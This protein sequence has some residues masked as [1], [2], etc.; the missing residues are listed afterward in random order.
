M[1]EVAKIA[2]IAVV[3]VLFI[4]ILTT[5][6][7]AEPLLVL[8]GLGAA[9]LLN[10]GTNLIFGTISFVTNAAGSILQLAVSL[11]Y[12]VFL[13]HRFAEC[14]AENRM[15]ARRSAWW[16]PCA[17]PPAPSCPVP[18]HRHR[19]SGTGAHA[20]PDRPDL[21]LAL[22]KGV[23]LSLVT[24][25]TFMPALTLAAYQWMDKTCHRPLLPS[26]DKFG[27]FVARIMLP[28]RWCWSS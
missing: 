22:A 12:S 1:T 11:D 23:V 9:I 5:D 24:V 7:W 25:F 16:M 18:D 13:I 8:T 4:L 19:L 26:F 3:Y 28:M 17:D 2:A 10:N 27:R 20:V 6:S 14:R 15:P 21:G